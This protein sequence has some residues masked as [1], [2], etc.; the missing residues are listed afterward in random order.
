MDLALESSNERPFFVCWNGSQFIAVGRGGEMISSYNGLTWT[1]QYPPLLRNFYS[2]K[3]ANSRFL[4]TYPSDG[5][6]AVSFDGRNWYE[7]TTGSPDSGLNDVTWDGTRFVGVGYDQNDPENAIV[8]ESSD[9]NYWSL[10]TRLDLGPRF[11][12][13]TFVDIDWTGSEYY[14]SGLNGVI[15]RSQDALIWETVLTAP[16]LAIIDVEVH[17]RGGVATPDSGGGLYSTV[18]GSVWS[19]EPVPVTANSV[20]FG[21]AAVTGEIEIVVG[22]AGESTEE[23]EGL[24]LIRELP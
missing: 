5:K 11:P 14:A 8:M 3:W 15:L 4:A 6:V 13:D 1:K 21:R 19:W 10:I 20:F 18:D 22:G 16:T 17:S 7:R 9:G 24:V 2:V 23:L 12:H